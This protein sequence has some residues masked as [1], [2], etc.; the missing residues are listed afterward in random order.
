MGTQKELVNAYVMVE[1]IGDD[2]DDDGVVVVVNFTF[3]ASLAAYKK[4]RNKDIK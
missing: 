2:D 4:Q 3:L 1:I